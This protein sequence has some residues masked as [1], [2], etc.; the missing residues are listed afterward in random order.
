MKKPWFEPGRNRQKRERMQ[1]ERTSSEPKGPGPGDAR[2]EIQGVLKEIF[3]VE[4]SFHP[5]CVEGHAQV[6]VTIQTAHCLRVGLLSRVT[7]SNGEWRQNFFSLKGSNA[8]DLGHEWP[9]LG[10]EWPD[11]REPKVAFVIR[12]CTTRSPRK[13]IRYPLRFSP[14]ARS[15]CTCS[16]LARCAQVSCNFPP[17]QIQ[18]R[19]DKI[20]PLHGVQRE[21]KGSSVRAARQRRACHRLHSVP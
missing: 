20:G 13:P 19:D 6:L 21:K 3:P 14:P 10:H 12:P 9:D 15:H 18:L 1:R 2:K 5:H 17:L 4:L 8:V 16:C 7:M 11:N